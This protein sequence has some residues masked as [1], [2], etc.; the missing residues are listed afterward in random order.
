MILSG[1]SE[2]NNMRLEYTSTE[3]GMI[4][5][6]EITA[7]LENDLYVDEK[8][9]HELEEERKELESQLSKEMKL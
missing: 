6:T 3:E 5:I 9:E 1:E 8:E 2:D 4:R 7:I